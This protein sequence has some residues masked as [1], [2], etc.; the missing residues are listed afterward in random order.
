MEKKKDMNGKL[1]LVGSVGAGILLVLAMF[2]TVVSAQT[3]NVNERQTNLF[4]YLK[5]KIEKDKWFPGFLIYLYF[6]F[7]LK[8]DIVKTIK[9]FPGFYLIGGTFGLI[10]LIIMLITVGKPG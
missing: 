1:M 2:S 4:Q 6:Q 5:E 3:M 7:M 8:L 9:W 10:L